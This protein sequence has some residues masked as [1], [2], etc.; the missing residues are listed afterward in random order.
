MSIEW[1]RELE[2]AL[3]TGRRERKAVL[4]YFGKDP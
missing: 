2:A 4:L 1:Q 3:D